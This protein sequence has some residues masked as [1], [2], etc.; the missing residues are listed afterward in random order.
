[1]TLKFEHRMSALAIDL[2][3]SSEISKIDAS[4][5]TVTGG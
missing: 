4:L 2:Y 3:L 5:S 1:M